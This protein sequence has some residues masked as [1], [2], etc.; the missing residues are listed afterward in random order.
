[1]FQELLAI[2]PAYYTVGGLGALVALWATGQL[3]RAKWTIS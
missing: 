1:M 2:Y 3:S